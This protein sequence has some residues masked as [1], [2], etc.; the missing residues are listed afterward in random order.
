MEPADVDECRFCTDWNACCSPD[1]V[2]PG[3]KIVRPQQSGFWA[4]GLFVAVQFDVALGRFTRMMRRMQMVPMSSMGMMR[5]RLVFASTMML[6]RFA[7]VLRGMFVVFSGFRVMFFEFL[8]HWISFFLRIPANW[9]LSGK[10]QL[11]H[12]ANGELIRLAKQESTGPILATLRKFTNL[13]IYPS[14]C[15]LH[16]KRGSTSSCEQL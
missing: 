9:T 15:P 11:R 1:S 5:R 12:K 7:M 13:A 14:K 10:L 6:G 4:F 8:W 2:P 3:G 16:R